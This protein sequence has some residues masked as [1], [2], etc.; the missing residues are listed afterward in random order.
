[1]PR[2]PGLVV[3][4]LLLVWGCGPQVTLD[5]AGDGSSDDGGS[6]TGPGSGTR[7]TTADDGGPD[8]GGP[9]DGG[10]ADGGPDGGSP[11][12]TAVGDD[13]SGDT[14][15]V[16]CE[17]TPLFSCS[18]P[19]DCGACPDD[20]MSPIDADGCLRPRCRRDLPCPDGMVCFAPL[21]WGGCAGSGM[22]CE[23]DR[24]GVCQCGGTDDCGGA[25]C[26]PEGQAPP[27]ACPDFGGEEACAEAGC[28]PFVLG[29]PILARP[30]G[31]CLCDLE[32][33]HCLWAPDGAS[34]DAPQAYLDLLDGRVVAFPMTFDP[35]P[36]G[37][38][39]CA[40]LSDPPPACACA[41]VLP[42]AMGGP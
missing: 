12:T 39:A 1:M 19:I 4:L 15:G 28:G 37:W 20:P 32:E 27:D 23:D 17:P 38:I 40:D 36:L 34:L 33:P 6:S 3:G 25:W 41:E 30:D 5:D 9:D 29:R 42:C 16:T 10:P 2:A 21:T 14:V 8:D 26:L 22:W 24:R 11:A 13:T 18:A 31:A 35:P 7:P